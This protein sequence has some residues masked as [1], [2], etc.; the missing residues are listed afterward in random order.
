MPLPSSSI[1]PP[2]SASYIRFPSRRSVVHSTEGIVSCSQPLAA[3]CGL[4]ILRAGGNAADAAVAVGKSS[5]TCTPIREENEQFS[6]NKGGCA[7][8]ALNVTE[9]CSTGIGGDVFLLFWDAKQKKVNAMNG[10][11][12]SGAKYDIDKVRGALG[13]KDGDRGNI[14]MTSIHAI[15]VPGAPAG[16]FDTHQNFGSGKVSMSDI[17]AP[18]IKLAE[19]GFPVSE[20]TSHSWN[21]H[22]KLLREASPNYRELLKRDPSAKDGFRAPHAGEIMK[23][24]DLARTFRTLAEEGREGFYTGRIAE[25]I[26]KQIKAR[27]GYME[28]D[29]LKHHLDSK[30]EPVDP[31]SIKFYGQGLRDSPESQGGIELWEHP[32]NGQGIVA[33]MSMGIIQELEKQGKIPTFKP[34][35]F[36]TAPYLHAIIESLRIAFSD[37]NWFVADPNVAEVPVKAMISPQYLA[38]RAKLFD[39]TKASQPMEPGKPHEFVSPALQTSDTVYFAVTDSE[40]N[41]ASFINSN[42]EAF[43]S[44]IIPEGCGFTLQSRGANFSLDKSH[45]NRLEPRKRP[46]HTIIPGMAT[47]ISDG[48]LHSAFGVM[49][50]FMQPQGHVQVLLGQIVGKLNPQQALDAPRVCI[51]GKM[52][53]GK[54]M[55]WTVHVE[56]GMSQETVD[57]LIKL[58]HKV[59]IM[60][61]IGRSMFGRGQIIRQS[62]DPVEGTPLWSA[63]SDMRADGAAY[64]L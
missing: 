13:L 62:V 21:L 15:T 19:K 22:E 56:D 38:E 26:I 18:A 49:G 60:S 54:I 14:P 64:P 46:Y 44:G 24:P 4:G 40:G 1:F 59:E 12:R 47:N 35:D 37:T 53:E 2:A 3:Q 45:P 27:G 30:S 31:I 55:D 20:I 28:L 7:A 58:G 33:L 57:G 23:N 43:G 36:N 9:P 51:G 50:L 5:A 16:W 63:G 42:Y 34:E 52:H 11:G 25:E 61:G 41:A 8:A 39:A 48:S 32:P 10:S 6:V 29:D 17:L